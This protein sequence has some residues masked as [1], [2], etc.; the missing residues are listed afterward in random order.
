MAGLC[1]ARDLQEA[2]V[3]VVLLE[4]RDR[5]GGRTWSKS[6]DAVGCIVDLGAE[7]VAPQHH[8]VLV[9]ELT[10]YGLG[11]ELSE[12]AKDATL[13]TLSRSETSAFT[14]LLSRLDR[15]AQIPHLVEWQILVDYF[16]RMVC[17]ERVGDVSASDVGD[18]K[19][20]ARMPR[21]KLTHIVH[22][23]VN[24]QPACFCKLF[25]A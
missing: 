14:S 16:L 11:L 22:S 9:K 25:L 2:N 5:V 1:A 6:F 18:Q 24:D 17:E 10:R 13:Q 15:I 4:G 8:T 21:H 7:W 20:S 23:V 3:D 12:A 19:F